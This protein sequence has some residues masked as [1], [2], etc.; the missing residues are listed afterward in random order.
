MK[1][2]GLYPA[3]V[4]GANEEAVASFLSGKCKFTDIPKLITAAAESLNVNIPYTLDNIYYITE[5]AKRF[6]RENL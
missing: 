6:V 1:K 2:G 4:N 3:L 5:E